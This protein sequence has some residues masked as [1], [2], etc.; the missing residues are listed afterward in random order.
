MSQLSIG[1]RSPA[2]GSARD[3]ARGAHAAAPPAQRG[4]RAVALRGPAA[5]RASAAASK[6]RRLTAEVRAVAESAP[7]ASSGARAS[8]ISVSVSNDADPSCT[9]VRIGADNRPGLLTALTAAFRDLGLDVT[10]AAVEGDSERIADTFFVLKDGAKVTDAK[11]LD[12]IKKCL[13]TILRARAG[14]VVARPKFSTISIQQDANKTELLHTLMGERRAAAAR[15]AAARRMARRRAALPGRLAAAARRPWAP[16]P[17]GAARRCHPRP[18][19][20]RRPAAAPSR[21]RTPDPR[22]A[23]A[24]SPPP[25]TPTATTTCCP[26]R[27]TS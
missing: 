18:R 14:P 8:D 23:I 5:R 1:G 2:L 20:S 10:R 22:C 13:E 4:L 12:N 27:R 17:A 11:E 6:G 16:R 9:Q 3:A 24:P 15:S 7:K 21:R 19:P 26:S 25:Q